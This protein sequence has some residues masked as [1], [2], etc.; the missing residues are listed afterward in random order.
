MADALGE[1]FGTKAQVGRVDLGFFNRLIL[2]DVSLWDQKGDSMLSASR[3]AAKVDLLALTKGRIIISSAQVF[4]LK[5]CLYQQTAKSKPN[6]QFVLDSLA[7]HPSKKKTSLDLQLNSLI[8][9]HGEIKY[10]QRDIAPSET[11]NVHHLHI[12]DFSSHIILNRLTDHSIDLNIKKLFLHEGSGLNLKQLQFRLV[13]DQRHAR[14]ENFKMALPGTELALGPLRLTYTTTAKKLNPSSL[15]YQGHILPSKVTLSDFSFL[16]LPLR[17]F[18]NPIFLSTTFRGTTSSLRIRGLDLRAATGSLNL[19]ADAAFKGKGKQLRWQARIDHLYLRRDGMQLLLDNMGA[20]LHIPRSVNR[21]GTISFR[22]FLGGNA[23]RAF[24]NGTISSE[25]GHAVLAVRK[26]GRDFTARIKAQEVNL[27]RILADNQFG[28]VTGYINASGNI[29]AKGIPE[30][31]AKG[32]IDRFDYKGYSYRNIIIDGNIHHHT[33]SGTGKINDQSI[34]LN[35]N[36]NFGIDQGKYN[37]KA[38]IAKISPLILKKWTGITKNYTFRDIHIEAEK[39]GRNSNLN[40]T[41]PEIQAHLNGIYNYSTLLQSAQQLLADKLPTLPGLKSVSGKRNNSFSFDVAVKGTD[42]I[43]KLFGIP[44]DLNTTTDIRGRISDFSKTA[45]IDVN[46]PG[47]TYDGVKYRQGAIR[48]STPNDTMK[49]DANLCAEN[50]NCFD[51]RA[52]AAHNRLSTALLFDNHSPKLH[53]RGNILSRTQFFKNLAGQNTAHIEVMPSEFVIGDSIWKV[54]SG[55]IYY[56]KNHLDVDHFSFGHQNQ[57]AIINGTATPS[58]NDS[59]MVDLKDIDIS[60]L[61]NLVNFHA[62]EFT[63]KASGRVR[64]AALF[65]KQPDFSSNLSIANFKFQQGE[66]GTLF[67]HVNYNQTKEQIDIRS[68]AKDGPGI[69]TLINGYVSP[70]HNRLDLDIQAQDTKLQFLKSFCGSFMNNIEAWG[71]GTL[72]VGGPLNN[73]NLTGDLIGHG[74]VHIIPTNVDYSFKQLVLHAIPNEIQF[75]GDSLRDRKGNLGILSGAIHHKHLTNLSFDFGIE[76]RKLLAYDTHEFADNSF[77]GT[78][79]VTGNCGI[80]GKSGD[81]SFDINV[82]PEQGSQIVYNA[83][84]PDAV[85]NESFIHWHDA[86]KDT[87]KLNAIA[88]H[89]DGK[90]NPREDIPT[91]LHFNFVVNTNQNLT[92]K[93][94]LDNQ[95]DDYITL[96]GDGLIRASYFNKGNLQMF[97]NYVVDHGIYT[98][99]IQNIIKKDFLFQQGGTIA[100]NG[101]PYRS[102]LN[103]QAI[104]VVNGVSLSDLNIGKSFSSNNIRVDCVMDITGTPEEPKASF[105]LNMPTLNSEAR[106]MVYSLLNSEEN[107][108]QQVLYLLAV[109][110]FYNEGNNNADVENPEQQKQTSLAMQS[111]L[112]GTISQQLN[113]V[114][115]TV[116]NNSNWNFGANISTGN[117]GFYNAEYEGLLSGRMFNNRLQFN[118][119]FGYR[120]KANTNTSFIGDFDIRYLLI[121]SGNIA[122][123]IYNQANDR[124]FTKNSLNTQGIGFILKKDFNGIRDLLGIK[125]KKKKESPKATDSVPSTIRKTTDDR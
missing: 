100:F 52:S 50:G 96:N 17:K 104:Y 58:S 8:I 74:K 124:Y 30:L 47:F 51:V 56:R 109:G 75:P 103:L 22:G 5:A 53:I 1:K 80:H 68:I 34:S 118:G 45:D 64:L 85:N 12:T 28:I 101:D 54:Q 26:D 121:P 31:V 33:I 13:A 60:Y 62:V 49:V 14:L 25:V 122:L 115:S 73:L 37:I 113:Q 125:K 87:L 97:G 27:R 102:A 55:D 48:L 86:S 39:Q 83:A 41:T 2:D 95:S 116:I 84:S 20:K 79:Y 36:G 38:D 61:L 6:Y 90:D 105:S 120:D 29:P 57:H 10:D 72:H 92:L 106:Q 43:K 3:L 93:L 77:Y 71:N 81:V 123:R 99:T 117:E 59:L 35:V 9:R 111:L 23:R 63:G 42:M 65:S 70:K 46:I 11:F 67:A 16:A 69:N 114:L 40:I 19:K 110:R 119:Q 4:G 82:T 89:R 7:A 107:M 108:N 98:L 112:S 76:G 91:D 24:V 18:V 94:L 78:V 32:T 15:R 66:M 44:L 88:Q 21:L